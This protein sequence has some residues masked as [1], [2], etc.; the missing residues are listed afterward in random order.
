M[1]TARALMS[2][3]R[4]LFLLCCI[5][6]D[7]KA[8]RVQRKETDKLAAVRS[9]VEIFVNNCR[10]SY[11]LGEFVTIIDE[12]LQAFRGRCSFVYHNFRN[13]EEKQKRNTFLSLQ[14]NSAVILLSTLHDLGITDE[15]SQKPEI[16]DYNATKG[17]VDTMDQMCSAYS[18]ARITRRW[19][20]VIF[21]ALL[22]IAGINPRI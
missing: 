18:V 1:E 14:K 8:T 17:A 15:S 12:K 20:L 16:L 9:I 6:F 2:Y 10:S 7:D 22:D 21:Y 19:P 13:F 5:R 4:F 11:S 3:K